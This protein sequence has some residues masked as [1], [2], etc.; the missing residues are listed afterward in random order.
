MNSDGSVC[1][2]DKMMNASVLFSAAVFSALICVFIFSVSD[3]LSFTSTNPPLSFYT[4]F[5]LSSDL[6]EALCIFHSSF[7]YSLHFSSTST[8]SAKTQFHTQV[9]YNTI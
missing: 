3:S 8:A 7:L 4:D 6:L 5:S 2:D 1:G 9:L